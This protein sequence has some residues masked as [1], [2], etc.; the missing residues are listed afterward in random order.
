MADGWASSG[1]LWTACGASAGLWRLGRC[2]HCCLDVT[3]SSADAAGC[4][5]GLRQRLFPGQPVVGHQGAGKAELGV[6]GDDQPGP[7]VGLLRSAGRGRVQFCRSTATKQLL[8]RYLT[9]RN[10]HPGDEPEPTNP[11][12]A[13]FAAPGHR[14][15]F[16]LPS[17][18]QPGV[19]CR[20]QA[21]FLHARGRTR[22]RDRAAPMRG[23]GR[24]VSAEVGCRWVCQCPGIFRPDTLKELIVVGP[25]TGFG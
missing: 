19:P 7:S 11:P 12:A 22:E 20:F 13:S 4:E 6:G 17:G 5:L 2:S 18:A 21:R 1:A 14:T 23:R 25:G 24:S 9:P 10:N 8:V 15:P 16:G 3:K